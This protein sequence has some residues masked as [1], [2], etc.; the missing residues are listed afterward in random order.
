MKKI[1]ICFAFAASTAFVKSQITITQTVGWLESAYLKWNPVSNAESYRVYYSGNGITDKLIDSQLIRSY[2]SYFRA[3]IPGLSAGNYT[4]K[5]VPV[6]N[7]T[8]GTGATTSSVTVLAQDRTGFAHS[9]GRIPGAYNLDGTLK[10]NAVVL[11]ITPDTKNTVSLNVTGANSNPCVGLQT[12]LDGFKKGND[13]RP[14][15]VRF[16]GNITDPSYLLNGDAVVENN[17]NASSSITLEGIGSDAVINGWGIRLKN[18]TNIEVRNLGFMLTDAGEGDNLSLQQDN[19][20]I[21]AHNNDLFYGKPGGDADQAKGDGALDA[22]KSTYITFSY[23][24]FWDNGKSCL[25]GLSEDTT[26]GLYITYHHNWF[27]H[28]DSRHPRIRFYSAHVYNNYYDGNSKYGVGS[29]MG[30]SVFVEGNYFRNCKYPVLTSKQGTDIANGSVGTFSSENGGVVKAYNNFMTGQNAF[31]PYNSSTAA[32]QFDVYVASTR[33][34]VL[35]AQIKA[36][37]GAGTYNNFDTNSSLY[38][39]S[40]TPDSPTAARDKAM[41][42]SGRVSGGDISWTFNNATDDTSDAVNTGLMALLQNYTSQM[43]YVQGESSSST[44]GQTLLIASN[45]SQTVA[46]GTAISP[47]IFT[48]GGTATDVSVS[49]LPSSGISFVKNTTNK[50]VTISGTPTSNVSFTITTIGTSGTSVSG[51]GNITVTTTGTNPQGNEVHNFTTS[52]LS[53]SFYS[54]TSANMNS[55]DGSASYDGITL[56]K[57]LKIESS[58]NISY[59]TNATS[60]LTLVF[61]PTFTGTIKVDGTS[62]TASSG[63]VSIPTIAAGSHSITKG[64]VANLYYIKTQY[65]TTTTSRLSQTEVSQPKAVIYP[66]PVQNVFS[67]ST[68]YTIE[69]VMITNSTGKVMKEIRGN[70]QRVDISNFESGVY[71]LLI[72]TNQGL[73]QEKVIK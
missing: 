64:S 40:M 58:T 17:K 23:N 48:W 57:R 30:S 19:T 70:V 21:W 41:Q 28:S 42:Y 25:L 13:T 3:D 22:K 36:F 35:G 73:L 31:I 5:V 10:A 72:K 12:I 63:I 4:F 33:N 9:D 26:S 45:N 15:A 61:D 24:H 34:E 67:I 55:T 68:P 27:D 32:S 71:L 2:G 8:E 62:Y 39:N 29:T 16:I 38:I 54:F 18:A 20:Y 59:S 6:I 52:G 53:S 7:N 65:Q 1:L 43:V 66:N 11:Y 51:T 44:S 47:M 14:L 69:S 37:Q 49:N 50:T 46:S 60:S 56:T